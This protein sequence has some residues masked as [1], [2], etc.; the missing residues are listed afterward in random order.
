MF[1]VGSED[2]AIAP[3]TAYLNRKIY[4]LESDNLGSFVLFTKDRETLDNNKIL[5]KLSEIVKQTGTKVLLISNHKLE[6]PR[7]DLRLSPLAKFTHAFIDSEK[8]YLYL[9]R[10]EGY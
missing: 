10:G 8:Y 9:V 5:D 1:I 7:K 4:Y 2:F 3:I 6:I